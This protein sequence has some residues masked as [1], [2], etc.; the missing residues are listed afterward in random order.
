MSVEPIAE[1]A[2][3]RLSERIDDSD[4]RIAR[5]LGLPVS[6]LEEAIDVAVRSCT[7]SCITLEEIDALDSLS[8]ARLAH[9]EGCTFCSDL[10]AA[11]RRATPG[12]SEAFS[13][14]AVNVHCADCG[15]VVSR[16]QIHG[17]LDRLGITE[18]MI[19]SLKS[20]MENV[21]VAEYLTTARDYLKVSSSR[22]AQLAKN[23]PVKVAT[24]FAVLALGAGLLVSSIRERE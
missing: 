1:L 9:I 12:M 6:E 7:P 22:A 18:D 2:F 3:E 10:S 17:V 4:I 19:A 16:D 20:K 5:V 11:I 24:G 23:N 13:D 8:P 14:L 15:A 21:D